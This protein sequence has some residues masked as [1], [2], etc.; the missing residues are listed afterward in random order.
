MKKIK[1]YDFLRVLVT[2]FVIISHCGYLII[3]SNYG[4]I[5]YTAYTSSM[6][7]VYKVFK[8]IV[9]LLYAFHMPLFMALSGALFYISNSKPKYRN[10]KY[11]FKSKFE[12]L[13]I[14]FMVVSLLYS[15]PIKYASGYFSDS[16]NVIKDIFIG[17]ILVQGN[18]HL[19]YLISL[20]CI[21]ILVFL[22]ERLPIKSI[23][24]K[25]ILLFILFIIGH[26]IRINLMSYIMIFAFWFYTGFIFEAIR[27]KYNKHVSCI[28]TM[29]VAV[30]FLI[31]F[32]IKYKTAKDIIPLDMIISLTGMITTYNICFLLKDSY[33][34]KTKI[35]NI[36]SND[37]FGMYLYSDPL[38]YVILLIIPIIGP[39]LISNN[40][41]SILLISTRFIITSIVSVI[42]SEL[43]RKNKVKYLV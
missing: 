3:E 8:I 28:K 29:F 13:M 34:T 22:L 36:M 15:I 5:D 10:F 21:F 39:W 11:I 32:I 7:I 30:L 42:I 1:E 41:G 18:S 9:R 33:I 35:F 2:I 17:Q 31:L 23:V 24:I 26:Y 19:W 38:N 27:D 12:R 4:G 25:Y 37:S 14:P 40:I 6:S 16:K 20:F 43:L